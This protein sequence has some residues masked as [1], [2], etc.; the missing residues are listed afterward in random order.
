LSALLLST[1][2]FASL[3]PLVF[4]ETSAFRTTIVFSLNTTAH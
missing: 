4:P 1:V 3:H 2:K